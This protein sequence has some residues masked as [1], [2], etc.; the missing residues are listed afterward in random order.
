MPVL[1]IEAN[2]HACHLIK[3]IINADFYANKPN[4][5]F[6]NRRNPIE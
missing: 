4:L 6:L 3:V 2:N 5:M 1:L